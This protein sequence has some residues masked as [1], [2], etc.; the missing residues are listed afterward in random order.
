MWFPLSSGGG[1][2]WLSLGSPQGIQTSL[3]LVTWNTS[4]NLSHCREIGPSFESGSLAVQLIWDRKH[5]VP[6]TYLLLRENSTCGAG[7]KLAQIFNQRQGISS[8]LGTIWG[9][10]SFPRVAV[11]ILI[12]IST[13]YGCL[14]ESLSI[15]E[16]VKPLVLY[17]V[18]LGIAKEQMR[19]KWDASCVDFGYTNLFCISELT[20]EFTSSCDS[21]LGESLNFYQENWGSLPLWFETLDCSAPNGGKSSLI[22]QR[23]VCVMGFLEFRQEPGVYSRVTAGMGIRNSTLFS[24]VRTPV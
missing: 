19:G 4:L 20:S 18:E 7:G 13:W 21:V 6:L 24:E 23:G 8:Q 22:S 9:A 5:R 12:F 3:P 17:A 15:P 2:L 16:E 10:W 14:R 1:E 11:L